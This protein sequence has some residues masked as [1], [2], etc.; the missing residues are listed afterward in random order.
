MIHFYFLDAFQVVMHIKFISFSAFCKIFNFTIFELKCSIQVKTN[1]KMYITKKR[2]D[3][4]RV[5]SYELKI[6]LQVE[7][8]SYKLPIHFTS[9]ELLFTS[10]KLPFT[11]LK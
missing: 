1:I 6:F 9:C 7:N 4:L 8:E 11:S 10:Y 3:N 2:C 5:A